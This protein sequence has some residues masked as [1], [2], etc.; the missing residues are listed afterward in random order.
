MGGFPTTI[1]EAIEW[2]SAYG[3]EADGGVT[4]TLYSKPWQEAQHALKEWMEQLGLAVKF[5]AIGNLFGRLVA[6]DAHAP[7][8][9]IGSHV[10]TVKSGGKYDGAYGVLAA[11]LAIDQ[12]NQKDGQPDV[13]LEVVSFCEEEGS[14]F[15]LACWGSGMIT[16][17]YSF[18]NIVGVNDSDG[19][20]FADA[21]TQAGFGTTHPAEVRRKD[22]DT[23]LELHIEQGPSLEKQGKS[24]GVVQTI[25]GQKRYRIMIKGESNHAGTTMMK[26]RRDPLHGAVSMIEAL[27]EMAKEFDED[28]VTTVGQVSVE[29]NVP[30]VIPS[31][32]V[33][34]VDVRHPTESVLVSFCEG[35][36]RRFREIST[37]RE[38]DY[39]ME[40]WHE[41]APVQ[42]DRN[43]NEVIQTICTNHHLPYQLMNSGAGHD[44][45]LF[46]PIC[47]TTIVFVPSQAGISHSPLE[48]T[49]SKDLEAGLCVLTELVKQLAYKK[50]GGVVL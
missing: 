43:L 21:M 31:Q 15:P 38:L 34:T 45:Q 36:S 20:T 14:R 2:L 11:I 4:R 37:Q 3:G 6:R 18:Q 19:I 33:F 32:V 5:D 25:V 42:M 12:L 39:E 27:Y 24:I 8:I 1:G 16:G 44:A 9:L 29:P 13:N 7:T 17:V 26:W 30:N 10:D 28:L 46:A 40:L 48:F 49:S 35:I 41:V 50:Q 23:F 22:I 47:P